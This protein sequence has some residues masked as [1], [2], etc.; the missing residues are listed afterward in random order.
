VSKNKIDWFAIRNGP[1][2]QDILNRET[3]EVLTATPN[4][5]LVTLNEI[6]CYHSVGASDTQMDRVYQA[7]KDEYTTLHKVPESWIYKGVFPGIW[8]VLFD[9]II[10]VQDREIHMIRFFFREGYYLFDRR[11]KDHCKLIS[12]WGDQG[13]ENPW[14]EMR[15]YTYKAPLSTR[16]YQH[17][18]P[19]HKQF[20]VDNNFGAVIGGYSKRS[21]RIAPVIVLSDAVE[22]VE[23]FN[24]SPRPK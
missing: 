24:Q 6:G 2:F 14:Q 16:M 7:M 3:L 1:N 12:K 21:C 15:D 10:M 20:Y 8:T 22:K 13:R 4:L 19:G 23:F 5:E 18:L 9:P 11:S 17:D